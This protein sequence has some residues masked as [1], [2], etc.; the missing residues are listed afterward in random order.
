MNAQTRGVSLL[1]VLISIFVLSIGLMGVA[2]LLPVGGFNI[3]EA[4]KADGSASCG[5]AAL[6]HVKISRMLERTRRDEDDPSQLV[7]MWMDSW[8]DDKPTMIDPLGF[9]SGAFP[10]CHVYVQFA[11]G[12]SPAFIPRVTLRVAPRSS[13]L[14]ISQA[15]A[16]RIFTWED[17]K[18][19]V[20]PEDADR[21]PAAL[22][23][24]THVHPFAGNY[25]WM[26][27]VTPSNTVSVIVFHKRDYN[28][29]T[30]TDIGPDNPRP[31]ERVA[32]AEFSGQYPIDCSLS[33]PE[34]PS[35]ARLGTGLSDY[36]NTRENDWIMLTNGKDF[37]WYRVLS[38]ANELSNGTRFV[39]LAGSDWIYDKLDL[40][41]DGN[42][43]EL[44]AVICSGVI[45]V[46][47]QPIYPAQ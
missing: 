14:A 42:A 3:A 37:T 45:G 19:F 40:T 41:G 1:E 17:D 44:Q 11:S 15:V 27:M 8:D 23:D 46:Y 32:V 24:N 18:V 4:N 39:W 33:M 10:Y 21:R 20:I 5:R 38:V 36:L 16:D 34:E 13:S 29:P 35:A 9:S 47:T 43:N 2:A 30:L 12:V 25:S 31:C 22:D 26:A 7:N 6:H 28:A